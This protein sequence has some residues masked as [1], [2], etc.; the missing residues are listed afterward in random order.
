MLGFTDCFPVFNLEFQIQNNLQFL[1]FSHA[2]FR[3]VVK[4][5]I[6][7]PW[8]LGVIGKVLQ[9]TKKQLIWKRKSYL[10]SVVMAILFVISLFLVTFVSMFVDTTISY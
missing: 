10:Q 2:L 9:A 3:L 8:F 5:V 6:D 4:I 1:T 7:M